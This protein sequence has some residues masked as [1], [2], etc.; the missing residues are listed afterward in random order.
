MLTCPS[1]QIGTASG[2]GA[3]LGTILNGHLVD[4]FGQKRVLVGALCTLSCLIFMTFFAPNIQVL[5]FGQFLCGFPWGIF[6]TVAPSYSSEVVPLV[7]RSYLSSFTNMA[8]IIG[9]IICAS[10]I[11]IFLE[12]DDEWGFRIPFG[13]QWIWPSFLIPLLCFAPE[14]PWHLV[15]KGRMKEAETSLRRLQSSK[16]RNIR[17][18]DTL[19]DIVHTNNLEKELEVGTSYWDC[20]RGF[21]LRR[22][23]VACMVFAGQ[24]FSGLSFAYN[25][26]YF[27][28]QVGLSAETTYTL[29]LFGTSLAL[30]AT[31]ANWFLLMPYYGR[32]VIYTVS[33]LV[34]AAILF[35]IGVL[36][37]W[38]NHFFIAMTQALLTIV[39][40]M[41]F[42]LS[43]GQLGWSIPAEVGSTRLR[44]KTIC[45][46][47]NAYYL[48][49]FIGGA[50]QPYMLNPESLNW[51]GY[52][53]FFWGTTA[54]LTFFW[55]WYRLPETK[56]RT[57]EEL[58][59]LFAR[60]I[61]ARKFEST[62]VH[63]LRENEMRPF[64]RKAAGD[65]SATGT[66]RPEWDIVDGQELLR[67]SDEGDRTVRASD[68]YHDHDDR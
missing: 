1:L 21:E 51:R 58:D 24:N 60:G 13:F 18:E 22:T 7:L 67:S 26:T 27:Y 49:G 32:R 53:G 14:S 29:S 5:A 6:A 46:A 56:G 42:Q 25:A 61:D 19:A 4:K 59:L 9:Q 40:T 37:I 12:R 23:E 30:L 52:T 55:A 57:Y 3:V 41:T 44:T 50:V 34:M 39:W 28:E 35:L 8:F 36:T 31:L 64:P 15:R 10:V 68:D 54:I 48:V 33:M 11:R 66:E 45:L 43:V 63:A 20:F 62:D 17:P 65:R 2:I 16:A 38:T 47:R